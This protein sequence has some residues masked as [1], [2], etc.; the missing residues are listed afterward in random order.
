MSRKRKPARPEV[1]TMRDIGAPR[2]YRTHS[3]GGRRIEW[4]HTVRNA[5]AM[6]QTSS[7]TPF[8][9]VSAVPQDGTQREKLSRERDARG[10]YKSEREHRIPT[11]A[12]TMHMLEAKFGKPKLQASDLARV[13]VE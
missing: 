11:P 5:W 13:N 8:V 3:L 7:R 2:H 4:T 12:L 10:A 9:A 1:V 6:D